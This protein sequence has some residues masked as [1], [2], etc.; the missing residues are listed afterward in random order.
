MLAKELL[1]TN[2]R[3]APATTPLGWEACSSTELMCKVKDTKNKWELLRIFFSSDHA[4]DVCSPYL[5][6]AALQ[7]HWGLVSVVCA[8]LCSCNVTSWRKQDSQS[9]W[10]LVSTY[11][12]VSRIIFGFSGRD[13][14]HS[15]LLSLCECNINEL[16]NQPETVPSLISFHTAHCGVWRTASFTTTLTRLMSSRWLC[17]ITKEAKLQL[18][19]RHK[20]KWHCFMAQRQQKSV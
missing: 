15:K 16:W 11:L 2:K 3:N 8:C 18:Q 1:K 19:P 17:Y 20:L 7:I 9:T 14:Y 5:F 6:K 12:Q 4:K 13:L 10:N